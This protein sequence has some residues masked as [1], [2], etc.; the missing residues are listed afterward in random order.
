MLL[1]VNKESAKAF[2]LLIFIDEK[3]TPLKSTLSKI[4]S[5]NIAFLNSVSEKSELMITTL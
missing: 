5:S 2:P 3:S 1:L 4:L